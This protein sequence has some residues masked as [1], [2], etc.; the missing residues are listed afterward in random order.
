MSRA[1]RKTKG[2]KKRTGPGHEGDMAQPCVTAMDNTRIKYTPCRLGAPNLLY[3][4][5][6]KSS[7]FGRIISLY[8][9]IHKA[10]K[11]VSE[12]SDAPNTLVT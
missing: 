5:S 6:M 12:L 9:L 8:L 4:V 11:A 3:A 7:P 2:K 10:M 1:T